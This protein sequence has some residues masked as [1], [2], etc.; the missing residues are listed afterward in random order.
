MSSHNYIANIIIITKGRFSNKKYTYSIP[1][2]LE[3]NICI[4][5]L[6]S[7][8]FNKRYVKGIITRIDKLQ[9]SEA[10]KFLQISSIDY[11]VNSNLINYI[12]HLSNYYCN[13]TGH[14]INSYF[15][16]ILNQKNIQINIKKKKPIYIYGIDCRS[17]LLNNIDPTK[18][19]IIYSPSIK[20]IRML[21]EYLTSKKISVTFHQKTGGSQES[22]LM[23]RIIN[24]HKLGIVISLTSSIFNPH[25]DR[26]SLVM[27]YWDINN[28]SY[29]ETRKPSFNLI[30]ISN[31]QSI[32]TDHKQYYYSEFPDYR[33]A[34]SNRT[35]DINIPRLNVKYFNDNSTKES[36]MNFLRT[37][38]KGIIK[39]A[40]FNF[41]FCSLDLKN[42]LLDSASIDDIEKYIY[43]ESSTISKVNVLVEPTV[44]YMNLLNSNR[45]ARLI[46]YL[47]IISNAESHL[48]VLTRHSHKFIDLLTMNN[49]NM[50]LS[51]EYTYRKKYGPSHN[52]KI[53]EIKSKEAIDINTKH[54]SGPIIND[55]SRTHTYQL[56]YS[57][58]E[59]KTQNLYEEIKKFDYSFINYL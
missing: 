11:I 58:E 8:Y 56:M 23:Q 53:I 2:N 7:V 52:V 34:R 46:R 26:T 51:E 50:W 57:L 14:T 33:Y 19:N 31:I 29:T 15:K 16:S 59:S 38:S 48:Y 49:V 55:L 12:E 27:H 9:A 47:N 41:E 1:H 36:L 35:I 24:E 21:Y 45:L 28:Y 43:K 40:K 30:D 6:V 44:S 37:E 3:N 54:I 25:M 42:E 13:P 17:K 20:S 22:L 10:S 5:Q 18:L 32:Y 4:N 39:A